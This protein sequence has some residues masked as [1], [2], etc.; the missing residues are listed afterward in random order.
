MRTKD[1]TLSSVSMTMALYGI[2][3]GEPKILSILEMQLPIMNDGVRKVYQ[4]P[5]LRPKCRDKELLATEY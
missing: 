3:K 5:W 1:L 2:R 4:F